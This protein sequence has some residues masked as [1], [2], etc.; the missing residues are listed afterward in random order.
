LVSILIFTNKTRN[1]FSTTYVGRV[2][3]RRRGAVLHSYTHY[4]R[5]RARCRSREFLSRKV[6]DFGAS[7]LW[8]EKGKV[9]RSGHRRSYGS[10]DI[11]TRARGGAVTA[12]GLAFQGCSSRS[13][14]STR[15]GS[16]R[17]RSCADSWNVMSDFEMPGLRSCTL[18]FDARPAL[19][20]ARHR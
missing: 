14:I 17:S 9:A 4:A 8:L 10:Y 18:T 16:F 19:L 3:G 7:G 11:K 13:V 1:G 20:R 15:F 6:A 5:A 12:P 2:G